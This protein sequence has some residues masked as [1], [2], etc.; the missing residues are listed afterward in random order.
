MY[1]SPKNTVKESGPKKTV[2]RKSGTTAPY[3]RSRTSPPMTISYPGAIAKSRKARKTVTYHGNKN[4][5]K[6]KASVKKI[7]VIIAIKL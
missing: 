3:V 6:K 7:R 4:I 5:L 1:R 2:E